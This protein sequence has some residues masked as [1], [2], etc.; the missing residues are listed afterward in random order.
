M[1]AKLE[2]VFYI[3]TKPEEVWE[4]LFHPEKSFQAFLGGVIRS[5]CRVGDDIE[6]VG[7]GADGE[8][9]VHIY[10]KVLEYEPYRILSYTDHPGP[11]HYLQHA[12]MESR[13]RLTLEPVGSC[14]KLHLVN[15]QWTDDNPL[16][17][18]TE[19]YWW[20]ILSN[21]KSIAET[22]RPLDFG[23]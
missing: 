15:D 22:G 14:T 4:V 6:F 21:I 3:G 17:A 5:S 20:M 19:Q 8:Q 16:F 2:Y 7:P 13:V 1:T 11:S 18:K 12:E 23:F 9:T 10:G